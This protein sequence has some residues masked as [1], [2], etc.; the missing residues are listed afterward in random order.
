MMLRA[1]D[2]DILTAAMVRAIGGLV[3]KNPYEWY[4]FKRPSD[5]FQ[6]DDVRWWLTYG[7]EDSFWSGYQPVAS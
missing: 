6:I 3:R 1:V 5:A 4:A 7:D 2:V